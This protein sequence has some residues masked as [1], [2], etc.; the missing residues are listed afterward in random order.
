MQ[1]YH[2]KRL[3]LP[4]L[5]AKYTIAPA[6]LLDWPRDFGGGRRRGHHNH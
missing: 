1:L 5:I 4:K 3:E 2:T 6:R